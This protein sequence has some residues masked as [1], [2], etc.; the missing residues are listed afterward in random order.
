LKWSGGGRTAR[1]T[2]ERR[3]RFIDA[4]ESRYDQID[5]GVHCISSTETDV[6]EFTK[7]LYVQNLDNITQE[8]DQ[9][10]R[11]YLVFTINGE[12]TLRIPVLRA[13]RLIWVFSCLKYLK[14]VHNMEGFIYSDWFAGDTAEGEDP[15]VAVGLVNF[16]LKST[17]TDLQLSIAR[18]PRDSEADLLSDWFAGWSNSSRSGTVDGDIAVRFDELLQRQPAKVDWVRLC[19]NFQVQIVPDT[20]GQE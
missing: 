2:R 1:R 14:D 3:L 15:A 20:A 7:A 10:G 18:N 17:G 13:A 4:V 11:N 6:S 9:R 5:F 16:L 12:K 8:E 19:C